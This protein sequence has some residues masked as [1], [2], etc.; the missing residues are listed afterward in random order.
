MIDTTSLT[1][2]EARDDLYN[3]I[4]KASKGLRTYEIKLR[5]EPPVLLISK[6]EIEGWLETLD[7]MASPEEVGAI[8]DGRKTKARISHK[9]MKKLLGL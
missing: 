1:A 5:G 4:R 7:V 3:L 2:S 9:K 8:E 6:E